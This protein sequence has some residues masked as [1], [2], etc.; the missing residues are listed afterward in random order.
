MIPALAARADHVPPTPMIR[1]FIGE[2][3][4]EH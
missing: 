1:E 3:G 4:L 2:G